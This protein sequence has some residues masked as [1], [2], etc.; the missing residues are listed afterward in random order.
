MTHQ[1]SDFQDAVNQLKL[2]EQTITQAQKNTANADPQ[3][4]QWIQKTLGAVTHAKDIIES[5]IK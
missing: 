5:S 1:N 2:A 4:Q 3:Q